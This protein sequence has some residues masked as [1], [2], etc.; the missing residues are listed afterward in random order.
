MA[1]GISF[2]NQEYH[3]ALLKTLA[4]LAARGEAVIVGRGAVYALQ[5]GPGFHIRIFASNEVRIRRL[6]EEWRTTA[7]EARRRMEKID[8][9]RRSFRQHHFGQHIEDMRAFD[10]AF[11]TD[12]LASEQIVNA[13]LGMMSAPDLR[14]V[15]PGPPAHR[16]SADALI[17]GTHMLIR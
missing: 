9:E 12:H 1:E 6:S 7:D 8:A 3:E 13:V 17:P 16:S 11:N 15:R 10:A 2:G 14:T 4:L 5:G